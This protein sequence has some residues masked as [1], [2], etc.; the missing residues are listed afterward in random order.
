MNLVE[1]EALTAAWERYLEDRGVADR[2]HL[3]EHYTTLV[4]SVSRSVPVPVE[5]YGEHFDQDELVACGMF[6]LIQAVE[7]FRLEDGV[8][9]MDRGQMRRF[10]SFATARIRGSMLDELRL[11][12][13]IPRTVK[14]RVREIA[15][16]RG[17]FQHRHGRAPAEDELAA[18]A[19]LSIASIREAERFA[20]SLDVDS[21]D[22]KAEGGIQEVVDR[23]GD[24][25]VGVNVDQL[26]WRLSAAIRSDLD[27]RERAVLALCYRE[28]MTFEEAGEC[29]GVG[30]VRI[31]Q[32]KSDALRK[33][34]SALGGAA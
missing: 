27:D 4:G 24:P 12:A 7:H 28:D 17:A 26:R 25:V 3:I 11:M 21:I 18:E 5:R 9:T 1:P 16:A 14:D 20:A 15:A 34:A 2:D 29:L 6:G 19:G 31:S 32:I 33:L 10:R 8:D 22:A 30:K 23:L 13:W